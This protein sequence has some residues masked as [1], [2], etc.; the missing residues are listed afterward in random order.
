MRLSASII[1]WMLPP[2][3]GI[4]DRVGIGREY[5][6]RRQHVR[7][8]E[9]DHGV[10]IGVRGRRV[11]HLHAFAVEKVAQVHRLDVIGIGGKRAKRD[12]RLGLAHAEQHGFMRQDGRSLGCVR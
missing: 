10:A 5:V 9:P 11:D 6:A 12:R 2:R 8:A 1:P 4:N 7:A 3:S